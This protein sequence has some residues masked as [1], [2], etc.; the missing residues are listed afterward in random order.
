M[1]SALFLNC[2]R[3]YVIYLGLVNTRFRALG[4]AQV[5]SVEGAGEDFG[6]VNPQIDAPIWGKSLR[7]DI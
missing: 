5:S 6:R 4:S 3:P 7:D 1:G 2:G